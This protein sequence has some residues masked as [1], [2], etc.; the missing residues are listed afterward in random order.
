MLV[1]LLVLQGV[2]GGVGKRD[3]GGNK[4]VGSD[5]HLHKSERTAGIRDSK[6]VSQQMTD[7][8]KKKRKEREF[9]V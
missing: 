1:L 2:V 9:S 7:I 3:V 8:K 6:S 4:N 5:K